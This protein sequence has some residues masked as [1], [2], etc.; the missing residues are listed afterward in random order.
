[1]RLLIPLCLLALV[2]CGGHT[3]TPD[4][5]ASTCHWAEG[6]PDQNHAFTCPPTGTGCLA[7]DA[8]FTCVPQ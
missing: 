1:M 6:D 2:A 5:G 8:Q 4:A 3:N 7:P